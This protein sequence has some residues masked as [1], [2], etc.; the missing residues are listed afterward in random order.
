MP[1]LRRCVRPSAT[2]ATPQQPSDDRTAESTVGGSGPVWPVG[3]KPELATPTP[4]AAVAAAATSTPA[5]TRGRSA[6][7]SPRATAAMASPP[8]T[9]SASWPAWQ[10][11]FAAT[12]ALAELAE[13]AAA[14]R[15]A[16]VRAE[17]FS[18][19]AAAHATV[20]RLQARDAVS[21]VRSALEEAVRAEDYATAAALRDLG[22]AGLVGWWAAA[23]TPA[24]PAGHLLRIAPEFGRYGGA[25]FRAS[26]V[27]EAAGWGEF[28]LD[29][30]DDGGGSEDDDGMGS[31]EEEAGA[32]P[33]AGLRRLAASMGGD[34]GG[35]G[36]DEAGHAV[37][38]WYVRD[39]R[40]G[41][42]DGSS[43]SA[44]V[45]AVS[46][47]SPAALAAALEAT[48]AVLPSAAAFHI[49]IENADDD[50]DSEDELDEDD[51]EEEE[52]EDPRRGATNG[53]RRRWGRG[54]S[55][56]RA[57]AAASAEDESDSEE[58]DEETVEAAIA[59]VMGGGSSGAA[60]AAASDDEDD[61]F[62]SGDE[63]EAGGRRGG[64][65]GGRDRLVMFTVASDA[66]EALLGDADAGE[67]AKR[68]AALREPGEAR[69]AAL[70]SIADALLT[71]RGDSEAAAGLGGGW[72]ATPRAPAAITW[73]SPDRFTLTVGEAGGGPPA[74]RA[75][76]AADGDTDA[77]TVAAEGAAVLADLAPEFTVV[78]SAA[79][80]ARAGAAAEAAEA[81]K[82]GRTQGGEDGSPTSSTS[83]PTVSPL[84]FSSDG[85]GSP[86]HRPGPDEDEH[87]ED[88][89]VRAAAGVARAA[90]RATRAALGASPAAS[91]AQVAD[92]VR[93]TVAGELGPGA[94]V[95]ADAIA[96]TPCLTGATTY[97]RLHPA[98]LTR[99]ADPY[100]GLYLAAFGAGGP[101]LVL[102]RRETPEERA[103]AHEAASSSPSGPFS[104]SS[105]SPATPAWP[106]S[107]ETVVGVRLASDAGGHRAR[108]VVFRAAL[109]RD[110]RL[111]SGDAYPPE[112]GVRGR[113]KAVGFLSRPGGPPAW[114]GF[115]D[116]EEDEDEEEEGLFG[117]RAGGGG[118][119][120][121]AGRP[122]GLAFGAGRR[123]SSPASRGR[124]PPRERAVEGELLEFSGRAPVTRGAG[125]GFV[126]A[127]PG[128][129][130]HLVLLTRV[131]L[132]DPAAAMKA[133]GG[134]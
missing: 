73:A 125:L 16:A 113:Y 85:P 129:R 22:G 114:G 24:D 105:S 18:A 67:E 43:T 126:W 102:V 92:A 37:L 76:T 81:K 101:E 69:R 39:S 25:L 100:T 61:G 89:L 98:S 11:H 90:A 128:D 2:P 3:V 72:A 33:A 20:T 70:A 79:A 27:A 127:A 121:R 48:A 58:E 80:L 94:R 66:S 4:P 106:A 60:S 21:S 95:T 28:G 15:D 9:S 49:S 133:G 120:G 31:D 83:T 118:R 78:A 122:G 13:E 50:E 6:S 36:F 71:G 54:R 17:D 124:L 110:G 96:S 97:E 131:P 46:A 74:A 130:R 55:G 57:R 5:A 82:G 117:P 112:L 103:R 44:Q 86:P 1:P 108:G 52:E 51:E 68:A 40:A 134:R 59:R 47:S 38:E 26:D 109:G 65:R 132:D 87:D 30:G 88:A 84:V 42:E 14:G 34:R 116:E 99:A 93:D 104:S 111:P 75:A 77:I 7:P 56:A 23:P 45:G 63:E 91:P 62:S 64:W 12:D 8:S 119:R 115:E 29:S 41:A 10:A 19:A 32:P 123:S 107:A 53:R 35:L